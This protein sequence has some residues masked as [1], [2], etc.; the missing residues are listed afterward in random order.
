MLKNP[1]Q[2][3]PY[4]PPSFSPWTKNPSPSPL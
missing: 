4:P 3:L 1:L 2:Q